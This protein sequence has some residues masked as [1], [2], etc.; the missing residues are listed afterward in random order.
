MMELTPLYCMIEKQSYNEEVRMQYADLTPMKIAALQMCSSNKV[1]E[2]LKNCAALIQQAASDPEVS[3]IVLPEMFAIFSE[4]PAEKIAIQERLNYGPLQS[5]LSTQAKAH[6]VWIVGGTI[7]LTSQYSTRPRAA[8]LVYNEAGKR[9][10]RYDK[11][12]L[13]DVALSETEYYR[14]SDTTEA[15]TD[16]VVVDTP[17]GKLGLAVCYDLRFPELFRELFHQG[18]EIIAVP[19]AF[20]ANTGK[21]H[22]EIL[23]RARAIDH[24]SY[25]V[26]ACQ[27]GLHSNGR[28]TY[29]HSVIIGPWGEKLALLESGLGVV[30]AEINKEHLYQVRRS[31]GR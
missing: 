10:A 13:F 24:F 14:E 21:A 1:E 8:C 9:V 26:T 16:S 6:D 20:T 22:W 31:M 7:P 19:T 5:F 17:A 4:N 11:M 28:Q 18:A 23:T 25:V 30:K 15:G 12:H 2:N 27:S 29:G 3:I